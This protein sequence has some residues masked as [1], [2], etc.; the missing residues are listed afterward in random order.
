MKSNLNTQIT[1]S[2]RGGVMTLLNLGLVLK[3]TYELLKEIK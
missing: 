1:T 3:T 2:I